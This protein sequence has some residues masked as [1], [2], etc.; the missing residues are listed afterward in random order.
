L[1]RLQH[2]KI[3]KRN[4]GAAQQSI[5]AIPLETLTLSA[6]LIIFGSSW[7]L[8]APVFILLLSEV[9]LLIIEILT[10]PTKSN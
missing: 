1:S 10:N 4:G 3:C 2:K 9:N 5:P 6:Y 8:L 7:G